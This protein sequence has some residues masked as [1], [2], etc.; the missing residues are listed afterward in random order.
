[1]NSRSRNSVSSESAEVYVTI[2]DFS[3]QA[4]DGLN[5][6]A[7]VHVEV[8][9][10]NSSGWW[11]VQLNNEEGWVPSSYLDKVTQP[12]KMQGSLTRSSS[13]GQFNTGKKITSSKSQD[14]L[15]QIDSVNKFSSLEVN[16]QRTFTSA[17]KLEVKE[18]QSV[19]ILQR[20]PP[21]PLRK[22]PAHNTTLKESRRSPPPIP[23]AFHKQQEAKKT[24]LETLSKP[25]SN[26]AVSLDVPRV[27]PRNVTVSNDFT[28][29]LRK[30]FES[31]NTPPPVV[32]PR[33]KTT[34]QP[35]S[36][37]ADKTNI[38]NKE[39]KIPPARPKQGPQKKTGPPRPA[40]SPAL[41]RKLV[42]ASSDAKTQDRWITC[43]NYSDTFDGCLS[44]T[45]GQHVEVI[46]DSNVDWWYVR[47]DDKEGY[48][49]VTLLTKETTAT[50]VSH[51]PIVKKRSTQVAEKQQPPRPA[52]RNSEKKRMYK[53]LADYV[54]DDGGLS[55]QEGD[56]LELLDDSDDWWFVKFGTVE[57][58]AP[59]TYL[60]A[61]Y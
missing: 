21:R 13:H 49:P 5:F 20:G 23:A 60:E 38:P 36:Q 18:T 41:K 29:A 15:D 39:K 35:D 31:D 25:V 30:K 11:Y 33:H 40:V 2:A 44:F 37:P 53:A 4:G 55:F 51:P 57:G 3:D 9:S 19:S 54:D 26:E 1:M 22:K 56:V 61:V 34:L 32:S 45:K 16:K 28:N 8:I 12:I 47:I 52:P 27:K 59:S 17:S 43:D 50:L 7:G 24:T 42:A 48:S 14:N 58:W 46:D 10:K 6:K